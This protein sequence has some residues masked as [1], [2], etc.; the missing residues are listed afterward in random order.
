M[1]GCQFQRPADVLPDAGP[2]AP[3]DAPT[4]AR[5]DLVQGTYA[6]RHVV[7]TAAT[8]RPLDL[9]ALTIQALIPTGSGFATAAGLAHADGTFE[10]NDVAPGVLYVLRLGRVAFVTDQHTLALRHVVPTRNGVAAVTQPTPVTLRIDGPLPFA[11]GDELVV[12]SRMADVEAWVALT[13]GLT[14]VAETVDWM[15][16]TLSWY[17]NKAGTLPDATAG[18]DFLAIHYRNTPAATPSGRAI[19]QIVAASD[20]SATALRDGQGNTIETTVAAP[21]RTFSMPA[22]LPLTQYVTGHSAT[23]RPLGASVECAALPGQ[24]VDRQ[25]DGGS[26]TGPPIVAIRYNNA[27]P[28]T[29]DLSGTYA[30]PFP[31]NWPRYCLIAYRR[32][33]SLR[34]PNTTTATVV[35]TGTERVAV[36]ASLVG[37]PTSPP[38]AL[39]IRGQDGERGGLLRNDGM[40]VEISWTGSAQA[41]QY[42]VTIYQLRA[43]GTRT[44]PSM[45]ITIVTPTPS[46]TVPAELLAGSDFIT[47]VVSAVSSNNAY[48]TGTLLPDGI[49]GGTASTATAMFR[50]SA[51][52]GDGSLDVGEDCDTNGTATPACDSDCT[53]AV[54]GDGVRNAAAGELCDSIVDTPGCDSDCTA[55]QCGDGHV[56]SE[57]EQCDDGGTTPGDGCSATCTTE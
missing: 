36:A 42:N 46:L 5:P 50:W 54:C 53:T 19:Q 22:G 6:F 28:T 9:S 37:T 35:Q 24:A 43:Q 16:D 3:T 1:A 51:T 8:E 41:T 4:D 12:V 44:T 21:A 26:R 56:N 32:G 18:D 55:N 47:F 31:A 14:S 11:T 17:G 23:S 25:P 20:I 30:D 7:G 27:V 10:I 48:A 33:R 15:N 39:R 29:L 52:C 34:V 2:D 57:T 40:P 13:P 45:L 38:T 49:P